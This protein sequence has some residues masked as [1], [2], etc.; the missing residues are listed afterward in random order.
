M[1]KHE[2]AVIT[3]FT[4][5]MCCDFSSFHEYAEKLLGRPIF[6]MEFASKEVA[7]EI[8]DKS[9]PEFVRIVEGQTND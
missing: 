6:T 7:K 2:G 1:T 9:Y 5:K 3:A 4:G 8:S